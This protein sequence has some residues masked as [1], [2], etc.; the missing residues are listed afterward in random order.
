[1]SAQY[2][3]DTKLI[4]LAAVV[5]IRRTSSQDIK[6]LFCG[7]RSAFLQYRF[8]FLFWYWVYFGVN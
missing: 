8:L 5:D 6:V 3:L 2:R 7:Y 4:I 1:M